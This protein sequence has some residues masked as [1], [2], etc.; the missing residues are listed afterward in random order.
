MEPPPNAVDSPK[1]SLETTAVPQ[2][3][4]QVN[5]EL[6]ALLEN[7][8]PLTAEEKQAQAAAMIERSHTPVPSRLRNGSPRLNRPGSP[9]PGPSRQNRTGSGRSDSPL[10]QVARGIQKAASFSRGP[11]ASI[12]PADN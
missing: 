9:R 11:R 3:M 10:R 12:G 7:S 1:D 6:K 4:R 2:P 8:P 5:K